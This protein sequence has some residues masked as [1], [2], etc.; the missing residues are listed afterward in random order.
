MLPYM[1]CLLYNTGYICFVFSKVV[2]IV[3]DLLTD[4]QIL[5]DLLD[6]S[7]RRGVAVYTLLE[8]RGIPYFLDMCTRL[9]IN[10]VHLR[11]RRGS[12]KQNTR[13]LTKT[14][15]FR[16]VTKTPENPASTLFRTELKQNTEE[17][18]DLTLHNTT[19]QHS[20]GK[21]SWRVRMKKSQLE[22]ILKIPTSLRFIVHS[23]CSFV[24]LFSKRLELCVMSV[25]SVRTC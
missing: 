6:A 4:L 14:N 22:Q 15:N 24:G 8:A 17:A 19:A 12:E 13:G 18:P 2:A 11:V 9:Q 16:Q 3:M 1:G 5:Q 25:C 20:T 10:A 7:S 23:L 21:G